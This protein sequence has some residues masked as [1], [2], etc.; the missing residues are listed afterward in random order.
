MGLLFQNYQ[1]KYSLSKFCV[2]PSQLRHN[3]LLPMELVEFIFLLRTHV[4]LTTPHIYDLSHISKVVNDKISSYG[5]KTVI[6]APV[7]SFSTVIF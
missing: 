3:V 7:T 4:T 5:A 2:S 1:I 6:T